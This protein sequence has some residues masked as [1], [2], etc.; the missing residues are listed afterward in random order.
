MLPTLL[1]IG[2][3]T[4][5]VLLLEEQYLIP[6]PSRVESMKKW[7]CRRLIFYDGS[8]AFVESPAFNLSRWIR[9]KAW[10]IRVEWI[11]ATW[12][13]TVKVYEESVI[14]LM[15]DRY[16]AQFRAK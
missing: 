2:V 9:R 14:R 12:I 3:R 7:A 8:C 15:I 16:C 4:M 13:W 11:C 1:R 6:I 5:G 10:S